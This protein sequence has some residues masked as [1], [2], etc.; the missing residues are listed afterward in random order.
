MLDSYEGEQYYPSRDAVASSCVLT[1]LLNSRSITGHSIKVWYL[2]LK[3]SF[4][5]YGHFSKVSNNSP[6]YIFSLMWRWCEWMK[7]KWFW[8]ESYSW[9]VRVM[10]SV[11]I[12]C[13]LARENSRHTI[14][15]F[16][17]TIYWSIFMVFFQLDVEAVM[18]M[19]PGKIMYCSRIVSWFSFS[20]VWKLWCGWLLKQ[21]IEEQSLVIFLEPEVGCGSSDV[22]DWESIFRGVSKKTQ[23][24]IGASRTSLRKISSAALFA[25]WG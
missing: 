2:R 13:L 23:F 15:G 11:I 14:S 5:F 16:L 21:C 12:D 20:S 4:R 24:V 6:S 1:S 18:W 17:K 3:S 7:G 19:N 22:D 10:I 8:M 25:P 9:F